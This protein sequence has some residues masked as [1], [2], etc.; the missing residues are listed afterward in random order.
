MGL[1]FLEL[2]GNMLPKEL[3]LKQMEIGPL[4]N[5]LYFIGDA[6]TK[7]IAVIDPA[8]DPKFLSEEAKRNGYTIKAVFLTHGHP[9]H[10]NGLDDI[11]TRHNVPAFIS[12]HEAD[13]YKPQH[14]NLVQI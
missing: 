4:Q 9:D 2:K 13:F 7:E 12:R 1:I 3:I 11:L 8:W 14:K 10:V 6:A 5:F